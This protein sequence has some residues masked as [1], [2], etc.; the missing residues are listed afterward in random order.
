MNKYNISN[1]ISNL[2]CEA[3]GCKN[4]ATE[5]IKINGGKFGQISLF[6]CEECISKFKES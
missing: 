2:I 3:N 5:E 4:N 1:Q 6:L